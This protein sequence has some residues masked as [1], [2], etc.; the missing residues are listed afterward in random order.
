MKAWN[1]I[2]CLLLGGAVLPGVITLSGCGTPA[3][4]LEPGSPE[5]LLTVSGVDPADWQ[6]VTAEAAQSLVASGALKRNDGQRPVLMISRIRNY[7]L[8]HLETR[9]L[10]DQLRSVVLRSGQATVTSAVGYGSNLD[11]AVRRIRQK[12]LDDLF[13]PGTVPRSGTV[14]APNLSLSGSITQQT[15]TRGRTEESYFLFHLTLTDLATGLA[16]WE[17]NVEIAKQGTRPVL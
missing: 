7:T 4:Y 1:K 2:T 13:D 16:V 9:L 6:R 10:T 15:V 5:S 17:H 3:R 11:P 12:E 8:Q 14:I